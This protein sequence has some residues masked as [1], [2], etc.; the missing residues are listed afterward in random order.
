MS[1]H[2][3]DQATTCCGGMFFAHCIPGQTPL[4]ILECC[5]C[6]RLW[7]QRDDKKLVPY[8]RELMPHIRM[9]KFADT[10]HGSSKTPC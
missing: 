3:S 6:G 4:V 5:R 2:D 10:S 9:A 1:H 8:D 7:H